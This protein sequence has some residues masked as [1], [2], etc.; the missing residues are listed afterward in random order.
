MDTPACTLPEYYEMI[1]ALAF[2]SSIGFGACTAASLQVATT[3]KL[4]K[5]PAPLYS[6]A[7]GTMDVEM[8]ITAETFMMMTR[9]KMLASTTS[10]TWN[11]SHTR[12]LSADISEIEKQ[13]LLADTLEQ[14]KG[15][16]SPIAKVGSLF[17]RFIRKR[18]SRLEQRIR[19][20]ARNPSSVFAIAAAFYAV[21]LILSLPLNLLLTWQTSARAVAEKGLVRAMVAADVYI[22]VVCVVAA[23]LV[24][25]QALKTIKPVVGWITL[26]A[27]ALVAFTFA[28]IETRVHG[29]PA[30]GDPGPRGCVWFTGI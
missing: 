22:S 8:G 12:G 17:P 26:S 4:I 15:K 29:N 30:Y 11:I 19:E 23:A 25:A 28:V 13:F 10:S 1:K 24:T 6:N 9:A 20:Y 18:A 5:A 2:I 16:V 7:T 3:H 14:P 21:A 27:L